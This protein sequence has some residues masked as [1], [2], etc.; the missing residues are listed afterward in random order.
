MKIGLSLISTFTLCISLLDAAP[1]FAGCDNGVPVG[2]TACA[3][4]GD[5]VQYLCLAGSTPGNSRWQAQ[6]CGA[7]T[8]QG[9]ACTGS[10]ANGVP[11][12]G[13]ACAY[14]GDGV[15]Y[16]CQPGSTPNQSIWQPRS[17]NGGSCQGAACTS[18]GR[19]LTVGGNYTDIGVDAGGSMP[20]NSTTLRN[21]VRADLDR[22]D[23]AGVSDLRIWAEPP[24]VGMSTAQMAT[25]V[26]IVAQ[27]AA[28]RGMRVLVA[29]V[30]LHRT[31]PSDPDTHRRSGIT[32]LLRNRFSGIVWPNRGASNIVWSIG[33]EP[34]GP[35]DPV[36]F[37]RWYR[38]RVSEMRGYMGSGQ[39]VVA[40]L[41]PGSTNHFSG[42]MSAQAHQA[43]DII[44]AAVDLVSVHYYPPHDLSQGEDLEFQSLR[45]W[46]GKA[47]PARFLVG[48]I[49]VCQAMSASA[50]YTRLTQWLGRMESYGIRKALIWQFLKDDTN[51]L[52]PCSFDLV[53]SGNN[54]VDITA[55][56]QRDG[57][58]VP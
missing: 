41:V 57:W 35:S 51:H 32:T 21:N 53:L 44:A 6:S 58:L 10:C 29:L 22:L 5:S 40:E 39:Q 30:D 11:I 16:I 18:S 8:C 48:E 31:S 46:L 50:R 3:Y 42:G 9:T 27:E 14:Q 15:E 1:S 25:R 47:G 45:V 38:D 54:H 13:T 34:A 36:G 4:Q 20:T 12:G 19:P 28:T 49:G 33:N 56:L 52:D 23:R 2:G 43:A 55:E 7:G 26:G 24:Y 17:C 37:A